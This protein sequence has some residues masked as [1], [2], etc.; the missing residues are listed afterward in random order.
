MKDYKK[1]VIMMKKYKTI[2]NVKYSRNALWMLSK[3]LILNK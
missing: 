1:E 3:N 2:F